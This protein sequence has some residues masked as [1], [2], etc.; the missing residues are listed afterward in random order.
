MC[1]CVYV[2]ISWDEGWDYKIL[3][4]TSIRYV[5]T[6]VILET[7]MNLKEIPALYPKMWKQVSVEPVSNNYYKDT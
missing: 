2:C 6:C 1:V 5:D 3:N 4:L 7:Q